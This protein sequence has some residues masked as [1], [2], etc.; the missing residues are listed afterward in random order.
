MIVH[1][2]ETLLRHHAFTRLTL[3]HAAFVDSYGCDLRGNSMGVNRLLFICEAGEEPSV[4]RDLATTTTLV[5]TPGRVCFLPCNHVVDLHLDPHLQFVSWQFSL[6]LFYGVD[7]FTAHPRCEVLEEVSLVDEAR[8]LVEREAELGTLWRV[9]EILYHL[10]ARWCQTDSAHLQQRVEKGEKY[11]PALDFLRYSGDATTTV[12][13]LA[14]R[15]GM[16]RD[17]FSRQFRRDMG[18]TP[19]RLLTRVLLNQA[20]A[21]LLAREASVKTVAEELKFSS[22]FYFS[23][24]FKQHTGMAP[25]VFRKLHAGF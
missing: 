4:I 3:V 22:E 6:E 21:R 14:E 10:I 9:N 1:R 2:K 11:R 8:L 24:F 19:K 16:R 5:L 7:V 12:G 25:S 13:Q 20:S 17:T 18:L 15:C 23:R